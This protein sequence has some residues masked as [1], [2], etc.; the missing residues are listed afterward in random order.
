M[1]VATSELPDRASLEYLKKLAKERLRELRRRNP[2]A[3]LAAAQ[4]AVARDHGFT[5]WRALKAEVDRRSAGAPTPFFAACAAGDVAAL[6]D[7]LARDPELVRA[8]NPEG[9]IG[10]HLAVR[11]PD[12]VRLLL[13]H[14]ADPNARDTGDNALPLHFAAGGGH[15][16]S[17]RAVLDAGSDVQGAG[18]LHQLDTIGWA[19]VFDAARRDVVNLLVQRG[20]RHHVFSAI[21][22][23]DL[24]LLRRVVAQDP[25]AI[26]RRLSRFEQEQTALHYVI[27]PADGLVGGRFR[28]GDHYRTLQLLVELGADLEARDA[29]GRTPLAVAMLRGDKEAM[30]LLHAAGAKQPTLEATREPPAKLAASIRR[31][32][33]MLGVPDVEATVAWYRSIGFELEGSHGEEGRRDWACVRFG[34]AAIMFIPSDDRWR[35]ETARLSLWL[36]TDRLDDLYALLKQRQLER[37]RATLAGESTE[38]PELRFTVD[39]YT[40]FYGQREFGIRDPNGIQLMFA[41]P[42]EEAASGASDLSVANARGATL[43]GE[44]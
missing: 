24:D 39:L 35:G 16:E 31:L 14:G 5:S 32:T 29:K 26:R 27:A 40:A 23:G 36:H 37:A 21:A 7:L 11:H 8:R 6:R 3:R 25:N 1:H 44:A 4:L 28:T 15:L 20:A 13:E 30:R 33:P 18:D 38:G 19:T 42:V 22:L 34:S 17:V 10:L 12:A 41:Q 43:G 2:D 9:S